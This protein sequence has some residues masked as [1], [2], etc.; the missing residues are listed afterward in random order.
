MIL[1][2]YQDLSKEKLREGFRNNHVRQVLCASTGA[3][4]SVIAVS[5]IKLAIE[6]ESRV[7][8]IVERRILAEQFS[9]HLDVHGI[10][11]GLY[12]SKHWRWQPHQKVQVAS[13]QT[14]ERMESLPHFDL[15]IIDEVHA[16]MR[17]SIVNMLTVRPKMKVIGLTATPFNPK[18]GEHFTNVV[19][20][21][22]MRELVD[23]G[24]LVPFRV[25]AAKEIDTEGLK[26]AFDG[27]FEKEGMET[28]ARQITGDVVSDYIRLSM[29]IFGELRKGIVFT[30][31]IAHGA[32]LAQKFN[33]S[34]VNAVQI[35]SN[36][37]D[38]FKADV[39][40]D[41][42]RSDTDIKLV[43][44]SE[45]LERGFD[46]S[47]IDFVILAKAVKKSFSKFVQMIGRGARP[48]PSK[49]VCIIQDHGSN[50]IRFSEQWNKLYGEGVSEL[51]SAPDKDQK[52]EP[53]KEQK[54]AAKCPSCGR[55][56]GGN[57]CASCGHTRPIQNL[58]TTV[59][60]SMFEL[61]SGEV[62]KEK[63]S[64]EFKEDWYN[65]MLWI[66]ERKGK[67]TNRAFHLY[68]EKF[69]IQP[70]WKKSPKVPSIEMQKDVEG[71]LQRANIAFAK[72]D[73]K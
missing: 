58:V 22:T 60:G 59:P 43:L 66:L 67:N 62:K 34:G 35:S 4:K 3:G 25:F 20:V 2:P 13:A 53:S 24:H 32:E 46:Q 61:T 27:E 44:S 52:K 68:R 73:K 18:L 57:P 31:G 63:H 65:S 5:M 64:S 45:I 37:D 49:E 54:E 55:I 72:M 36:D 11:H 19:N 21:I 50:W 9:V 42:K 29:Q 6:K 23:E 12:M 8:F 40:K 56:G 17:K 48:H 71:Y 26:T 10:P 70:A 14:L 69:G 16:C 38:E 51:T 41:F 30:S 7:L 33:E 1:R 39:L 28:R 15:C 47:D